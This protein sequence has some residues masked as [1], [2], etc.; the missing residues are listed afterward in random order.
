MS[1][2]QNISSLIVDVRANYTMTQDYKWRRFIIIKNIAPGG[3]VFCYLS[4]LEA[5]RFLLAF[6]R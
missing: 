4:L 6:T 2:M 1:A 3:A 5:A